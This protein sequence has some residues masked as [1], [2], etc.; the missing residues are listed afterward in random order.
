MQPSP[1]FIVLYVDNAGRSADFY[2]GLLGAKPIESSPGFAM[3]ALSDG[4]MLGLWSRQAVQ[5]AHAG[6]AGA[7]E[8]GF[9][10]GSD[11]AVREK[12]LA[13]SGRGTPILQAPV[14]MDFGFTFVAA[15]P[16]GHRLR[17]FHPTPA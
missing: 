11:D 17:V 5:P 1:H 6:G 14:Q 8:L 2:A 4:L 12:H 10:V 3:F 15:D 7:V 16:D 13:W 9:P